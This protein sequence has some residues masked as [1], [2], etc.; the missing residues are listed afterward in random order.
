MSAISA[1]EVL[2]DAAAACSRCGACAKRCEVLGDASVHTVGEV[3]EVFAGAAASRNVADT[4]QAACALEAVAALAADRPELVYA[5]RRCCMCSSCTVPCVAGIEAR[6]VFAAVR[7]LL[8][9]SGAMT[10]EGFEMTQVDREW[11]IFSVYRAVH[12]IGYPDLPHMVDAADRGADTLFFPGCSLASYAPDVCRAAFASLEGF[13]VSAVISEGCCGSPLVSAGRADRARELRDGIVR[14]ALAAGIRRVVCVCPGCR[15]EL[16][17]VAGAQELEFVALPQILVDA[18][19][20]FDAESVADAMERGATM[21]RSDG[22]AAA[23]A[24]GGVRVAF[25]DSC[26]DRDG[27][28]GRPLRAMGSGLDVRELTNAGRD[29]L[30]C[31]AGGAVSLVDP[32]LCDRRVRRV[33]DQAG[34][35]C[36]VLVTDCPTCAYTLA[37]FARAHAGA[38]KGAG[39]ASV[40]YLE[41]AYGIPFDW[42]VVF[43]QLEGMWTGEYGPWVCQ[44][45]L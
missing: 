30:C 17:S 10:G 33:L 36:D 11:H 22:A 6:E 4:V 12:G 31:G 28:F 34:E 8:A 45:L 16:A 14:A 15:D 39:A 5:V 32:S 7:E 41:L 19:V 9:L 35:V 18:G 40:N 26:H 44:Q 24:A 25:F 2:S 21:A 37:A 29:A 20:R 13:G 27:A 1:F 42:D 23:V 43:A 3:A 38:S